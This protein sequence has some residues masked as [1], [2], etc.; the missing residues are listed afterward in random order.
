[1]TSIIR[2]LQQLPFFSQQIIVD[3]VEITSGLSQQSYKVICDDNIYYA[4]YFAHCADN[5]NRTTEKIH[6]ANIEKEVLLKSKHFNITFPLLFNSEQWLITPYFEISDLNQAA[7]P[8]KV[9]I[10]QCVELMLTFQQIPVSRTVIKPIDFTFHFTALFNLLDLTKEQQKKLNQILLLNEYSNS[11]AQVL[12]HGD[13]NFSNIVHLKN[14]KISAKVIDFECC[15]F[16]DIEYDIAMMIAVNNLF[17][18]S[19][20]DEIIVFIK[21]LLKV[22]KINIDPAMVM[23]YLY[24]CLILNGLWFLVRFQQ[25]K[26]TKWQLLANEQFTQ[27]DSLNMNDF[28]LT[29][30][31]KTQR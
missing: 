13:L 26:L 15:C 21:Q 7:I 14:D 16:A 6:L 8:L 12:C 31:F 17:N 30:F 5:N 25:T 28:L 29:R 22:K 20:I 24:T 27:A 2:E 11:S 18:F 9:K 19:D 10:E 1:M 3:V 4:K 23:R